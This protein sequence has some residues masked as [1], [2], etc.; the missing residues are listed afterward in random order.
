MWVLWEGVEHGGG[1]E[2]DM[3]AGVGVVQVCA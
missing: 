1:K 2:A 3:E